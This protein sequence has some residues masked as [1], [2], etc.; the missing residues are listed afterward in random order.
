[1]TYAILKDKQVIPVSFEE[2]AS[3]EIVIHTM[4]GCCLFIHESFWLKLTDYEG[5]KPKDESL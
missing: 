3:W 1:M 2:Y 5:K 4:R